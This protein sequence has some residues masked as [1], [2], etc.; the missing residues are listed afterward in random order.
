V[1]YLPCAV[2]ILP[3]LVIF[4]H[5]Q[6]NF[7]MRPLANPLIHLQ[8]LLNFFMPRT[9]LYYLI[10][11]CPCPCPCPCAM[12]GRLPPFPQIIRPCIENFLPF[13][14]RHGPCSLQLFPCLVKQCACPVR[15]SRLLQCSG[16]RLQV[17]GNKGN[18]DS[19]T[20]IRVHA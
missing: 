4:Y 9:P 12:S 20:L 14:E 10:L 3:C 5:V 11:P 13:S 18:W 16:K 7:L 19:T 8:C 15:L 1:R 2:I 17:P 6:V